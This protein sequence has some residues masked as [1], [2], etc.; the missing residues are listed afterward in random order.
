VVS[1]DWSALAETIPE[2]VA[3][4]I[5]DHY[6][7]YGRVLP[8]DTDLFRDLGSDAIDVLEILMTLEECFD[9][10]FDPSERRRVQTVGDA[11][12]LVESALSVRGRRASGSQGERKVQSPQS[13]RTI[14]KEIP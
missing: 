5:G 1:Y 12:A 13:R 4:V 11:V 7:L 3:T 6:G 10:Y 9:V 2:A 14:G 8:F